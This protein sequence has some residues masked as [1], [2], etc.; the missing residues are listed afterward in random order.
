MGI[1]LYTIALTPKLGY[2]QVTTLTT[3]N[4]VK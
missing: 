4:R 3:N 2:Y 1:V